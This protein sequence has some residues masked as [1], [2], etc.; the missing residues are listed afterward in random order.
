[1]ANNASNRSA[2][3][4]ALSGLAFIRRGSGLVFACGLLLLLLGDVGR[5]GCATPQL[6]EVRSLLQYQSLVLYG[7]L[8]LG[9]VLVIGG[10]WYSALMPVPWKQRAVPLG[11][12]VLASLAA[13]VMA[14]GA[15]PG[16]VPEVGGSPGGAG[17]LAAAVLGTVALA[18]SALLVM[19]VARRL[20]HAALVRSAT[21][22][23]L[24]LVVAAAA[25]VEAAAGLLFPDPLHALYAL[26]PIAAVNAVTLIWLHSLLHSAESKIRAHLQP[27][28]DP[29]PA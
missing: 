13:V 11:G 23:S 2:W 21:L 29:D 25:N 17:P 22:F 6:P 18:G 28:P 19:P 9:Y 26:A 15:T 7:G 20:G 1:M 8:L 4:H 5:A 16:K 12:G 14:I 3:E 10:L 24:A 27:P